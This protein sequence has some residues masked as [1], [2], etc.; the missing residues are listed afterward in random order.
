MKILNLVEMFLIV[1]IDKI[2]KLTLVI[3][4]KFVNFREIVKKMFVKGWIV[5]LVKLFC[6]FFLFLIVLII[7]L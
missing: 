4:N 7:Y 2:K 5:L 3:L 6:Y 1:V